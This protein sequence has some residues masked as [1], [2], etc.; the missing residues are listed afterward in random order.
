MDVKEAA[1]RAK[2]HIAEL[3]GDEQISDVGL[4][5]IRFDE[6]DTWRV[7][8]GFSRPWDAKFDISKMGMAGK[9]RT[10]KVVRISDKSGEALDVTN[11]EPA[12]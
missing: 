4:E 12:F 3:F 11:R 9:S 8:I 2:R 6:P 5:E 7:T 10:F 1:A